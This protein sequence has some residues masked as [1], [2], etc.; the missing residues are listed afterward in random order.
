MSRLTEDDETPTSSVE[1]TTDTWYQRRFQAVQDRPKI[2]PDWEVESGML[3]CHKPNTVTDGLLTDLEA[4]KPVLPIELRIKM[5]QESHIEPQAG[6]LG[7][8]KT[9]LRVALRY[10]RSGMF[11]DVVQFVRTC[12][13]CQ[14]C[15]VKQARPAGM[16]G[17]QVVEQPWTVVAGDIMGPFPK[18]K[19]GYKYILVFQD[20]FTKWIECI[21]PYGKWFHNKKS[22]RGFGDISLGGAGSDSYR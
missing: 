17:Q 4:W 19:A 16:M 13:P 5:L 6:H 10:Y 8:G 3:Y 7:K 1:D 14:K 15:K 9:Y 2:F 18:S 12:S 22:I 21:Y 11:H 20:L